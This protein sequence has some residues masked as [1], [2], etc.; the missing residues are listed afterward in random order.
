M[1]APICCSLRG[2]SS[3]QKNNFWGSYL[4]TGHYSITIMLEMIMITMI[5]II[6]IIIII[7]TMIR[8][9]DQMVQ[10]FAS[11]QE[12]VIIPSSGKGSSRLVCIDVST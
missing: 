9:R 4:K 8:I 10:S 11:N 5:I 1:V 2:T 12:L 7:M 6:I 3:K